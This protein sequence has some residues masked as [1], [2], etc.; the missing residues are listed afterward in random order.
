MTN[1]ART[2]TGPDGELSTEHPVDPRAIAITGLTTL[3]WYAVPDVVRHRGARALLKT[4]VL[5]AGGV[6]STTST[7]EGRRA[8]EAFGSLRETLPADPTADPAVSV[9]ERE[10]PDADT[11]GRGRET[12]PS[13]VAIGAATLGVVAGSVALAVAGEKWLYRRGERLRARGT[14]LPHTRVALASAVVAGA[15]AALEPFAWKGAERFGTPR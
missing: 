7:I 5:V 9:P 13:P 8:R 14:R 10:E 6:L 1:E 3:A 15:L 2:T 11:T 12:G 4:G